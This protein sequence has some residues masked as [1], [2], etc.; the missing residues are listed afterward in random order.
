MTRF[1]RRPAKLPE[2]GNS[3]A[4]S[5]LLGKTGYQ[6]LASLKA[7]Q[8]T[9]VSPKSEKTRLESIPSHESPTQEEISSPTPKENN[10]SFEKSEH[11]ENQETNET[12]NSKSSRASVRFAETTPPISPKKEVAPLKSK[13]PSK[14]FDESRKIPASKI[15]QE[16]HKKEQ[17]PLLPALTLNK[18]DVVD[19]KGISPS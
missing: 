15:P 11:D 5:G 18:E 19:H 7:E 16:Y 1:E 10:E 6:M 14:P 8:R 12:F 17:S 4:S 3:L 2:L 13:S 9:K